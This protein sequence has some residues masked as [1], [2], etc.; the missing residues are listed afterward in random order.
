MNIPIEI[1]TIIKALYTEPEFYVKTEGKESGKK[2]QS[3]GIR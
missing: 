1:I 2:E 3:S